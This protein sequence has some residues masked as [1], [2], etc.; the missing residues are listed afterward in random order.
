MMFGVWGLSQDPVETDAAETPTTLG[1][2]AAFGVVGVEAAPDVDCAGLADGIACIGGGRSGGTGR[3]TS[4]SWQT[5][6]CLWHSCARTGWRGGWGGALGFGAGPKALGGL[7]STTASLKFR[8]AG[9][10][11]GTR[12]HPP[13]W[14]PTRHRPNPRLR[15]HYLSE[16]RPGAWQGT[17]HCR[18]RC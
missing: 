14:P 16:S 10:G 2:G 1:L 8:G 3:F 4:R 15:R 18:N 7:A 6:A 11:G 9:G 17:G 13:R 12:A 5:D